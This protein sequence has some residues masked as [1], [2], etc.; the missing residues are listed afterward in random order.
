VYPPS[1]VMSAVVG[2]TDGTVTVSG[3]PNGGGG[4]GGAGMYVGAAG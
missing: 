3:T 4:G 2:K 1:Y